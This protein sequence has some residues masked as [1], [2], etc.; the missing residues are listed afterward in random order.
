MKYRL[1]G[2]SSGFLEERSLIMFVYKVARSSNGRTTDSGP[3]NLGSIPSL[4][5]LDISW[6]VWDLIALI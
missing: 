2:I 4:A 5:T 6:G 3:V 1:L